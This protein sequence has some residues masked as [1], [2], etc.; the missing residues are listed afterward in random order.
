MNF[1][2]FKSIFYIYIKEILPKNKNYVY[3]FFSSKNP[4]STVLAIDFFHRHV[5]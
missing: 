4:F 5:S 1:F 2:L 3:I